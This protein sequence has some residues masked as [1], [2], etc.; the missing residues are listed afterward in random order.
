MVADHFPGLPAFIPIIPP[1]EDAH[2]WL[3]LVVVGFR[4]ILELEQKVSPPVESM[5]GYTTSGA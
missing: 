4:S 2:E 1:D 5:G 3:F